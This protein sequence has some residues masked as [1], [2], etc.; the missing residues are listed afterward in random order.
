MSPDSVHFHAHKPTQRVSDIYKDVL[1]AECRDLA[2]EYLRHL[3]AFEHFWVI[4]E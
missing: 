1:L 4:Q 2:N 3:Q